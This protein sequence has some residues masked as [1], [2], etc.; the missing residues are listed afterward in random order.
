MPVVTLELPFFLSPTDPSFHLYSDASGSFGCE[1]YSP[2]LSLWFK[3]PWPQSWVAVGITAKELVPIVVAAAIW[4][5]HWSG[6]H[7]CFRCDNDAVVTVIQNRSA[8]GRTPREFHGRIRTQVVG[9]PPENFAE[10]YKNNTVILVFFRIMATCSDS[11]DEFSSAM[12]L[13]KIYTD[14]GYSD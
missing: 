7:V 10:E 5:P 13:R 2:E 14:K 9:E 8:H 4:G 1:A 6:C 12:V 11:D 3:L